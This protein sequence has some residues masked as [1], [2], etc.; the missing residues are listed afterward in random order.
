M[1]MM[2]MMIIYEYSKLRYIYI[3]IYIYILFMIISSIVIALNP[4]L[5]I[6]HKDT[7]K[8]SDQNSADN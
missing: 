3:Y 7:M 8:V 6:N 5:N 4:V 2:R 1:M